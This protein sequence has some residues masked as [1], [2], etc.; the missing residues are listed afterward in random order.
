MK[1]HSSMEVQGELLLI[2]I[3]GDLSFDADW[4]VLKDVYDTAERKRLN[5]ILIDMLAAQGVLTTLERYRLGT[6]S[7][8][9]L[10]SRRMNPKIAFVGK[11]P[12]LDGFG[13]LV[14]KNRGVNAETFSN[15]DEALNWLGLGKNEP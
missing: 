10:Q 15:R 5:L 2:T 7:A 11:P 1:L 8:T 14:G 4:N 12:A 13:V 6:Q 9:Y 3:D